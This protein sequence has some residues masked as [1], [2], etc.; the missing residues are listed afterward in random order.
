[1]YILPLATRDK[2]RG[3]CSYLNLE[4]QLNG[5]ETQKE[6]QQLIE[7]IKSNYQGRRESHLEFMRQASSEVSQ[8]YIDSISRSIES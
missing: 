3:Y 6:M 5:N 1:M 8:Y 7:N 4:D 2:I